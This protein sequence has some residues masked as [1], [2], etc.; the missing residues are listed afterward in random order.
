MTGT[1]SGQTVSARAEMT[2]TESGQNPPKLLKLLLCLSRLLFW[3]RKAQPELWSLAIDVLAILPIPQVLL[4][5]IFSKLRGSESFNKI[6][7]VLKA[8]VLFQYVPRVMLIRL[9]SLPWRKAFSKEGQDGGPSKKVIA[10]KAGFNLFMYIVASHIL[11]GFWYFFSIERETACWHLACENHIECNRSS[12]DCNDRSVGNYTFLN[13]YCPIQTPNT[14][15][16]DF[17]IFQGALQSGTVASTDFS[18][19][20]LYCFW[21]GLRNLSSFGSNLQTSPYIWENCFAVLISIAGLLLFMYF[22]GRL[23]MY[24]QWE[25]KRQLEAALEQA[26]LRQAAEAQQRQAEEALRRQQTQEEEKRLEELKK[27]WKSEMEARKNKILEWIGRQPRLKEIRTTI[28][29]QVNR[30]FTEEENLI[31]SV[32]KDSIFAA[33]RIISRNEFAMFDAENPLPHFPLHIRR[34][35]QQLLCLPVLQK[36]PLLQN[37]SESALKLISR[38]F[39]EQVNYNDNSYIFREGE[40][41]DALLF[42]T[43]GVVL[44]YTTSS[45]AHGQTGCLETNDFYG[46]EL[47][48]WALNSPSMPDTSNLP[49]STRTLRCCTK[50]E[51]FALSFGNIPHMLYKHRLKYSKFRVKNESNLEQQEGLAASKFQAA[52]GNTT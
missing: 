31:M 44:T 14:T 32:A 29:D 12:F 1:E 23:Q 2:G 30:K 10:V 17:G 16:F 4:P 52:L 35:I 33:K 20:I 7:E 5:I 39:L 34:K 36:V 37:E 47:L 3:H 45:P 24:M 9:L 19:K 41:L 43:R 27:G 38:D 46:V 42:I 13:D 22:L 40:P 48:E 51:A 8:V 50:V 11:G 25:G 26:R 21:W 15:A 49:L 6:R 28:I 18:R